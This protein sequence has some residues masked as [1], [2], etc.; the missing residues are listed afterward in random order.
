LKRNGV[1]VIDKDD[2]GDVTFLFMEHLYQHD[3]RCEWQII[4]Y[5]EFGEAQNN[6]WFIF[7]TTTDFPAESP[8]YT[9]GSVDDFS[10]AETVSIPVTAKGFNGIKML[11]LVIEYDEDILMATSV[12]CLID[13][14]NMFSGIRTGVGTVQIAW[15]HYPSGISP[16]LDV[17]SLPDDT[18]LFR[19]NFTKKTAGTTNVIFNDEQ[20][21]NASHTM[22]YYY[23]G[24]GYEGYAEACADLPYENYYKNGII[25]I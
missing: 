16:D 3:S 1:L 5:N 12:E 22:T 18:E 10:A 2:L 15:M 14:P 11:D 25:S 9:I 17:V 19:I 24:I 20:F 4:P 8:V 21:T 13:A 23:E 7:G 6:E